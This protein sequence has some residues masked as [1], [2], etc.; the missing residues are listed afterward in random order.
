MAEGDRGAGDPDQGGLLG[1]IERVGRKLER[2]CGA[3][4]RGHLTRAVRSGDQQ[5][6]LCRG[7][8]LPDP[9]PEDTL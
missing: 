3:Q 4:Y 7:R 1:G 9:L 2:G 6:G 8:K 5:R